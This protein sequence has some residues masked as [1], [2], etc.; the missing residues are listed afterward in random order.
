MAVKRP[1]LIAFWALD[2]YYHVTPAVCSG[3]LSVSVSIAVRHTLTLSGNDRRK[4][5]SR[6]VHWRIAQLAQG[7]YSFRDKK[8][9]QKFGRVHLER[10][11]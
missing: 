9:T 6:N 2:F 7:L 4:L 8:L 1:K 11:R 5:G 3:C 10:G